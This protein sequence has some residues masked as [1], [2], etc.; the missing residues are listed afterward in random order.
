MKGRGQHFL[1]YIL[2]VFFFCAVGAV[3]GMAQINRANLNGTVTDPSGATVPGATV[4]VVA[5]DTGF[6]RQVTTGSSGVYSINSLP[7]GTYDLTVSAKGFN[8]FRATSIQLTVGEN[9]TL[10]AQLAVGAATTR[11]QVSATAVSLETNNAQLSTVVRSQQVEEIPLNGR[12]WAGLMTLT[13]GAVNLGGGGQRDLRFVG[14]GTDD[15]NYT[16][17]GLDATGVQEQNQ[18]AGARLDV[19]LE[20]IAEFRVS[21]SVYTADQGGSAG[22]QVSIVSKS[23]TN[24]FHGS[25]FEFLRNDVFDAR[26]PFDAD[27]PAFR[28]NQFGGSAGGPIQKDRSF[29]FAD[30]EGLR[31]VLHSTVIGFVPNAA[32]RNQIAANSPALT[33]FVNSWPVGQTSVD[34]FTDQSTFVGLNSQQENSGMA[35]L[36][37]TFSSKTSIFG[38]VNIDDAVINA[39]LDNVGGRDNPLLRI[40][41]Y[42]VQLTHVFSPTIV[43]ELRGGVNRS[44]LNHFGFGTSPASIFNGVVTSTGVSVGGYDD[45]SETSLDEEIGTTI[46]AY[47][48]LTIVK[49]RHTIK[50]GIGIERHRLNNSSEAQFANGIYTYNSPQDF[51]NNTVDSFEFLGE[52]T[53]GGH[54][55]TYIMP[56][57]QDTFKIRP[58]LTLTYGLRW[59][60]YT[61]LTEVHHR[62]AVVTLACGGFCPP[63]TPLYFPYYKDFAPRLGLAWQ[64]GGASGKTVIRAGFGMYFSPNQMDDFSD[65]HEST[66]QRFL[67]KAADVPGL[68]YPVSPAQLVNPLFSPKAWD[69]NR[70]DGYFED[71]DLTVQ[72]M[73]PHGFLGQVAYQGSEGHRL[74]SA[75]RF[76]RCEDDSALTGNC[77]RPIPGFGE[78]NQ[79]RNQGNSNFHSLQVSARRHLTAGWLWGTEYMWS[80]GLA[81]GGFGAGEYPHVEDYDCIRCSYGSSQ[82]DVRHSLS[83]NSVY[84]LPIGPGK[85]FLNSDGITG[86]LLGGWQLSGIASATSGRPI[87]ILVD[88]SSTDLPDGVTRNQRPNLVPGVPIYPANRTINNW[89]NPAAFAVP[90]PGTR[91]NLGYDFGRGPGYYEIDTALEK[92]TAITER[93][94]LDFRAEAFNLFNHP[95]YGD[96]DANISDGAFGTITGQLNDGATGIGSSRRLQFMLRL[97]F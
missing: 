75:I 87:D 80:H 26:S 62:Q 8:T 84:E 4:E 25:G 58:N 42:V 30:Y 71:W 45:P 49:G 47:D 6:T 46:D 37:H 48:D 3:N 11:V 53:L 81:W 69:Q 9:R 72:R 57:A 97:E 88:R 52:L 74:F 95:I 40:S 65:G 96:P 79:K 17:D 73:L 14:R 78:F 68:A 91:G 67:I 93:L 20:S 44:A 60:H 55:R 76:N 77:V 61:V 21:S 59:E 10:N 2:L 32:V 22:A 36:D 66:A 54:R 34:A 94:A 28:L 13:Q 90:A 15:N 86:K 5:P 18:K 7:I 92:K 23:G 12:D 24:N 56:Y 1:N 16:F 50:M 31:Q 39:P 64:P 89:F 19:S 70:R 43:N 41:N 33:Q 51:I 63:G 35:R 38:H 27:I 82:I 29:F 83:V 85:H